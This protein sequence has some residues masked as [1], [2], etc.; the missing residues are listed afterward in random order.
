MSMRARHDGG[1]PSPSGLIN[2]GPLLTL[3]DYA[4]RNPS[5]K[6]VGRES[7]AIAAAA[8]VSL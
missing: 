2:G 4:E 3:Y 7:A 8:A 6:V 5:H 1:R